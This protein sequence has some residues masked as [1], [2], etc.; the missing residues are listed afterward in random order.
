MSVDNVYF[1]QSFYIHRDGFENIE[2][3]FFTCFF[4]LFIRFSCQCSCFASL[5][6]HIG[7]FQSFRVHIQFDKL[8]ALNPA[9]LCVGEELCERR[10]AAN[11][12]SPQ[13]GLFGAECLPHPAGL[14][15]GGGP[16]LLQQAAGLPAPAPSLAR[17]R[18]GGGAGSPAEELPGQNWVREGKH[19]EGLDHDNQ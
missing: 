4:L 18:Q 9:S 16:E 2:T 5:R 19:R 13:L 17:R 7:Y 15:V 1:S 10:L 3:T 6:Q 11:P 14:A 12:G 8:G